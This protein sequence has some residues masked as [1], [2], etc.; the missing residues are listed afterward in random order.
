MTENM[1]RRSLLPTPVE[2]LRELSSIGACLLPVWVR[3]PVTGVEHYCGLSRSKLYALASAGKIRSI[4]VADEGRERGCRLF[5]LQSI[6]D[7]LNSFESNTTKE[8][9]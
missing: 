5:H 3:P 2:R 4:S 7:Y 1:A 6:L 8:T 9:A